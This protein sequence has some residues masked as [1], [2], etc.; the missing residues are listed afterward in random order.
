MLRG[1]QRLTKGRR[2]DSNVQKCSNVR[3]HIKKSIIK[4]LPMLKIG[5]QNAA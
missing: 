2:N 5:G 4:M 1:S 3:L